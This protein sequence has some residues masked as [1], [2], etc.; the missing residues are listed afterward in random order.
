MT[1]QL[2]LDLISRSHEKYQNVKIVPVSL[3][4][5]GELKKF[6]F[7]MYKHFSPI[8]VKDCITEFIKNIDKA[9]KVDKDGFGDIAEPYLMWLLIKHFTELGKSM[10]SDFQEQ[11]YSLREMIDTSA[12]F[13]IMIHF[14]QEEVVLIK[15]ELEIAIA[16]FETNKNYISDLRDKTLLELKDKTLLD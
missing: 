12:F 2:T 5:N 16:T 10:P 4:I 14:D 11:F 8:G 6:E 15:E 7:E 1:E 3:D 13:Q 9:R